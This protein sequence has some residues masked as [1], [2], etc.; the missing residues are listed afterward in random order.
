MLLRELCTP[1]TINTNTFQPFQYAK[2][3]GNIDTLYADKQ[4]QVKLA[5]LT[6]GEDADSYNDFRNALYGL[7]ANFKPHELIDLG[8]IKGDSVGVTEVVDLL[9]QRGILSIV[10][11]KD[12]LLPYALLRSFSNR[13]SP[14]H[15]S[16]FDSRL[17]YS[18]NTAQAYLA[19]Y[20]L[21]L[22]PEQLSHLYWL[23]YQSYFVDSTVLRL[24]KD[25]HFETARVGAIRSNM[26]ETEPIT[27]D[28]DIIAF[29]LSAIGC[30][31]APG[32]IMPNPNGFTANEV[33]QVMRYAGVSDRPSVIGLYG[34]TP[35]D[36]Y[37]SI[38]ALLL[39]QM[40]WYAVEGFYQRKGEFPPQMTQLVRYEVQLPVG[41]LPVAFFKSNRSE[42]WW[43]YIGN[44]NLNSSDLDPERL[45]SCSYDDYLKTCEGDVPDRLLNALQRFY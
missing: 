21:P 4:H 17:D 20:L 26:E 35:E 30:T 7:S 39:A 45:L 15:L 22:Y 2:N 31:D 19:D 43:F 37:K 14:I 8:G 42:R 6:V 24:M 33:C 44:M 3:I 1:V 29:N 32:T 12:G 5:I 40:V 23:G 34:Y 28:C 9:Q 18:W 25:K 10:I 13:Q 27:R 38:T 16:V 11:G 36:D 41:N